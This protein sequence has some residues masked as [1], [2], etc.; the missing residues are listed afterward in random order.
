ME[1]RLAEEKDLPEILEIYE[2][3]RAF[4]AEH[5]NPR[6]WGMT[7]WPPEP[8]LLQDIRN[9][10]LYVC[11]KD[12]ITAAVFFYKAGHSVEPTYRKIE[13]SWTGDEDYGV[14][15]RIASSGKVRGAGSFC[16]NW[17]YQQCGHLRMD[18]HPDNT[19]MQNLLTRLG[20]RRTG[21]IHVE[22]DND[23]R[24]AYEK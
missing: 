14:V 19:V 6:Q 20:F 9:R 7:K 3:A 18:T 21:I 5:G 13:G 16:I 1:I 12:G 2:H 24:Y 22:E 8:L 23:P 11:A 10:N 4:M 17:A 15:H